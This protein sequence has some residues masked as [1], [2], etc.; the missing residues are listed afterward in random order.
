MSEDKCMLANGGQL[1][2]VL[3]IAHLR[4]V[5]MLFMY[6]NYADYDTGTA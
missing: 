2:R 4:L 3:K 5:T 6:A 1:N